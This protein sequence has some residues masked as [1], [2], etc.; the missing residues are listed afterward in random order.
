MVVMRHMTCREIVV[1]VISLHLCLLSIGSDSLPNLIPNHGFELVDKPP[2]QWFNLGQ[3]FTNASKYWN[4]PTDASPDLYGPA[5]EIP[6]NWAAKGFGSV[7]PKSG[8]Y[9]AGITIFGCEGGKP[10]C[11]EYIQVQLNEPLVLG[12]KYYFELHVRHLYSSLESNNLGVYF[13]PRKISASGDPLLNLKPQIN[14]EYILK[15]DD[16]WE[17]IAYEFIA[18]S[19]AEYLVIGNFFSDDE[20]M[21]RAGPKSTSGYS[22]YYIDD[23]SLYKLPPILPVPIKDDDIRLLS[24]ERGGTFK[25]NDIYFESDKSELLPRSFVELDKLVSILNDNPSLIIE[26]RGHTDNQGDE[27]YNI[28]L[29]R[30]RARSV[31]EY[32]IRKNISYKRLKY[33]GMGSK[34]PIASNETSTGR[35]QNRRVEFKVLEN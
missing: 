8:K 11:R 33:K 28:N 2:K 7:E 4:S 35:R 6:H 24:L 29:S 32:L 27:N 25:L 18:M 1:M 20:T 13:S 14:S 9:M 16:Y 3:D 17:K 15:C 21:T 23:V 34:N 12:Q 10:H 30:E 5:I 26:I 22:Y 31:V 19:E